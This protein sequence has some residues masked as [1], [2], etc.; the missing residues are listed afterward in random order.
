MYGA[1]KCLAYTIRIQYYNIQIFE[2]QPLE[3]QTNKVFF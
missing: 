3:N 1:F 2:Y